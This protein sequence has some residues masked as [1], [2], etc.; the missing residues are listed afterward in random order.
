MKKI[1]LAFDGSNFSEG[2]FEFVRRLNDIQPLL[3]TGV[4]VPQVAY[5]NASSYSPAAAFAGYG[6]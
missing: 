5:S 6:Y 4:F 2:A 3:V 1:L